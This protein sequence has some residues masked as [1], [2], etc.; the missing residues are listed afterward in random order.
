MHV[1]P[2]RPG[3]KVAVPERS[4]T[5]LPDEGLEVSEASTYWYRRLVDGDVVR[6]DERAIEKKTRPTGRE[7]H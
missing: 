1:K 2:A 3:L 5:W 6:T 7:E 4:N